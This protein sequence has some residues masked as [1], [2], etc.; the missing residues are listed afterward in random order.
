MFLGPD[1]AGAPASRVKLPERLATACRTL[2]LGQNPAGEDALVQV[3]PIRD[4]IK[5]SLSIK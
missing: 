4:V 5:L 1:L 3:K 2:L